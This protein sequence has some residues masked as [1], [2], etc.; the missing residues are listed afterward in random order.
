MYGADP[1]FFSLGTKSGCRRI[2]SEEDVL[3]PLGRENIGSEKELIDSI[4]EMR[5]AR[6]APPSA[7]LSH[8]D[9]R[10]RTSK[11]NP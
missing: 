10:F 6:R 2:F 3:H 7:W 5:A 8:H 1:Q 11:T 4:A 9:K